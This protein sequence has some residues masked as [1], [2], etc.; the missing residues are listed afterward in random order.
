MFN[1]WK[2]WFFQQKNIWKQLVDKCPGIPFGTCCW[3]LFVWSISS[4][5]FQFLSQHRELA[6]INWKSSNDENE[7]LNTKNQQ[8]RKLTNNFQPI[9]T[10]SSIFA[11]VQHPLSLSRGHPVNSFAL[12]DSPKPSFNEDMSFSRTFQ[13]NVWNLET[14]RIRNEISKQNLYVYPAQ[15][16]ESLESPQPSKG[17]KSRLRALRWH[18]W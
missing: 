4:R 9:I 10:L 2:R 13:K 14:L 16:Q 11:G 6:N 3:C 17:Q 1:Y 8:I 15:T 12:K 7:T 18:Q 5:N